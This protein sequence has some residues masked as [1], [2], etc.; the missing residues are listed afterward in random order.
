MKNWKILSLLALTYAL[1]APVVMAQPADMRAVQNAQQGQLTMHM[2]EGDANM[3]AIN[4]HYDQSYTSAPCLRA[5]S[6][7]SQ[8]VYARANAQVAYAELITRLP[9]VVIGRNGFPVIPGGGIL[10]GGGRGNDPFGKYDDAELWG[11][12]GQIA[13]GG[14]GEFNRHR[15]AMKDKEMVDKHTP[16]ADIPASVPQTQTMSQPQEVV[17]R[18]QHEQVP[19]TVPQT[20]APVQQQSAPKTSSASA[21]SIKNRTKYDVLMEQPGRNP[22]LIVS[23]DVYETTLEEGEQVDFTANGCDVI[24]V[25]D[26]QGFL[27]LTCL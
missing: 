14:Y 12:V 4:A 6:P 2:I 19:A 25:W 10:F 22:F 3:C 16:D 26:N 13:L 23:G 17:I 1:T 27:A 7:I 5:L 21:V 20:Q 9:G 15:E 11:T 8:A 24:S 18:V